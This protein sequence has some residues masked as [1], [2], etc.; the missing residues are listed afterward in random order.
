[1]HLYLPSLPFL[2]TSWQFP[3]TPRIH[4]FIPSIS[5]DYSQNVPQCSKGPIILDIMAAYLPHPYLLM[6]LT[7][8]H[9]FVCLQLCMPSPTFSFFFVSL[10]AFHS[11]LNLPD[12]ILMIFYQLVCFII[13]ALNLL[14][15]CFLWSDMMVLLDLAGTNS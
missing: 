14:T 4:S 15:A 3:G 5:P 12:Q 7:L 11:V 13:L 10:V 8:T 1:M 6:L 2:T 9:F